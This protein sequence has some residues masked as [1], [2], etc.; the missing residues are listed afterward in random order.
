M[1][2]FIDSSALYALV[3]R[4]DRFH[5]RART[6]LEALPPDE[7]IVTHNY[8]LTET[9]Q[10]LQSRVGAAA[11][12]DLHEN[13]TPGMTVMWIEPRWHD[14]ALAA[15]IGR[16]AR[17]PSFVDSVSFTLMRRSGIA[18]ALAFDRHFADEGFELVG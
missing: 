8:A 5:T 13:V 11:V 18:R 6:A 14:E 9:I 15:V 3:V 10:L 7:T 4:T 2:I 17:S 16:G 1:Q 12:R